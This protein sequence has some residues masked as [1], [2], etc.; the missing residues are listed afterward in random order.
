ME[1][2]IILAVLTTLGVYLAFKMWPTQSGGG[3]IMNAMTNAEN[4]IG[5]D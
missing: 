1:F 4:K 3:A 2:L 5:K